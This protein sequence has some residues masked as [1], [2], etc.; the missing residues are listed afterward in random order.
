MARGGDPVQAAAYATDALRVLP[1]DEADARADALRRLAATAWWSG[2][3]HEAEAYTRQA[4]ALAE[5]TERRDLWVRG[6]TT[7]QWLL[8]L[9]LELDAAEEVLESAIEHPAEGI[10]AVARMQHALGSLRRMQGRLDEARPLLEEARLLFLDAGAAGEAAWSVVLLGWIAV[11]A[12]DTETAER[13]FREAVRVFAANEDFGRLCEAQ[14]ALAE[15]LLQAGQIEHA[16]RLALSAH[17]NV[18]SHDRTSRSSTTTTLGLVRAA[19]GRDD[20][21]EALLRE[22]IALLPSADYRLLEVQALVALAE[23]L[24]ARGRDDEAAE[25]EAR[26]PERVP[27]WLG[28]EDVGPTAR[29]LAPRSAAMTS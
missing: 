25:L 17:A 19:Q 20:E 11:T 2:D 12:G 9:R 3:L 28:A 10:L 4:I 16:E 14:R 21:A 27:A 23:F 8:E 29:R 5:Q 18:S 15:V 24:R 7:L 22:A 6:M 26:L 13:S 1:E